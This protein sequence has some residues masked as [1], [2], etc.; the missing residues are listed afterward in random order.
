MEFL[1]QS[2]ITLTELMMLIIFLDVILSWVSRDQRHPV[3]RFVRNTAAPIIDPFRRVLPQ[4]G[5]LDISPLIP[6]IL[7]RIIHNFLIRL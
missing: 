4:I 3:I 1:K 6:I 2:L 5:P 7:L